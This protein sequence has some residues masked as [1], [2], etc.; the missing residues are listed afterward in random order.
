MG[1]LAQSHKSLTHHG[2][3]TRLQLAVDFAGH[4]GTVMQ[5]IASSG[6]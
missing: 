3:Y 1:N 4:L 6:H 5:T 2:T